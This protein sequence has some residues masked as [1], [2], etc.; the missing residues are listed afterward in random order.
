MSER[1]YY[2]ICDDGCEFPAMT[3][4]QILTAIQQAVESHEITDVDSGFVTTLKE[5]NANKGVKFWFGT[6]AQFA[7]LETKQSDTLYIL[8]DDDT[9]EGIEALQEAVTK[10]LDGT[11]V[12]PKAAHANSADSA[13]NAGR[14][15]LVTGT[16][17][18]VTDGKAL[19]NDATGLYLCIITGTY[20]NADGNTINARVTSLI[21]IDEDA[22]WAYG[23]EC[24][25]LY[26]RWFSGDG[27]ISAV[28]T[29]AAI[30]K[31]YKIG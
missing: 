3:K 24:N 4:E 18:T 6:S 30:V 1:N 14:A 23:S 26:A 20:N 25:G 2:V 11:T 17:L 9:M 29:D 15:T 12:V 13:T 19:M 27:R 8:T 16:S 31:A 10:I 5:Q 28:G 21:M 22:P 7:A